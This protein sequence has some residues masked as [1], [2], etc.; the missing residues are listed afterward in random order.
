MIRTLRSI[1]KQEKEKF[2]IPRSVQQTIPIDTI[3]KDGIF[4]VGKN[5]YSKTFQFTD[6]NY[7][8]A[9][10][11]DKKTLFLEYSDLLN[12]FDSGAVTK[13]TVSLRRI[14]TIDFEKEILLPYNG[15]R[16]DVY[17]KEYNDM[18][19]EKALGTNG[20]VRELSLIHI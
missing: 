7:A 13:L 14:N 16:L 4:K 9:S 1:S 11:E 12:S 15:D 6:I 10:K 2:R 8:T 18:L 20:M 17:R 19:R 5:K 3:W